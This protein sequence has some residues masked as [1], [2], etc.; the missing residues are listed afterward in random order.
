MNYNLFFEEDD[1]LYY[2]ILQ[3]L[4]HS[5]EQ[6]ISEP[7]LLEQMS[8]TAYKLHKAITTIN[9]DLMSISSTQHPVYLDEPE[10]GLLR[11]NH[12]TTV[13]IQ[14][15]GLIYLQRS[16]IFSAFEY[17][18]IYDHQYSKTDYM[19]ENY[20]S[21][22]TFYHA[23]GR[24]KKVLKHIDFGQINNPNTSPEYR[25]RL[26][27]FQLYYPAYNG[28][29][30]PFADLDSLIEMLVDEL[31][32]VCD[33]R[34]TP[35]Q[36]NKLSIFLKIWI[37]RMNGEH[38]IGTTLLTLSKNESAERFESVRSIIAS[39]YL[40]TASDD[41]L[42]YL[43]T[44]LLIQGYMTAPPATF[45]REAMPT[46]HKLTDH[47]MEIAHQEKFLAD[48][49]KLDVSPLRDEIFKINVQF[50]TFYVEPTTFVD[51]SQVSFFQESYPIF[52]GIISRFIKTVHNK[53]TAIISDKDSVNLYFSYMFAMINS[54]PMDWM[55]SRV[56]ICV[57]FSQGNLY[58]NY[59]V[60]TLNSFSNANIKIEDHI[61]EDTDI[62][63]SD[64][65]SSFISQTQITWLDP[66]TPTDWSQL[67]DTIIAIKKNKN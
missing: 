50:T 28:I 11:G 33:I 47:F 65:Y 53:Q 12:L 30:S 59:I 4:V 10:K 57:D 23:E 25:V 55:A 46:A 45:S 67:A 58:T 51:P 29:E 63:L 31:Q 1:S 21:N 56:H 8:L 36:L 15:I 66:P 49:D 16:N 26:H 34:Y 42:D 54:I 20:I 6:K 44:F 27:L 7:Q 13:V 14:K 32:S 61:T 39:E 60:K 22:A 35:T 43:Y 19:K 38:E 5:N 9:N 37:L 40:I 2:D 17:N 41:E 3:Q 18:Y 24:M 48:P 64:F 52:D 62:Y